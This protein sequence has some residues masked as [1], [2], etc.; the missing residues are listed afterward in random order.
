VNRRARRRKRYLSSYRDEGLRK[1]EED[2]ENEE[3]QEEETRSCCL[4]RQLDTK[5]ATTRQEEAD[6]YEL[7][8]G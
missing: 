2:G 5:R 8:D 7:P 4:N 1:S 3:S 6:P